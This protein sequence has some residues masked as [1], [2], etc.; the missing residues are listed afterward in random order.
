M[1]GEHTDR[2]NP[3]KKIFVQQR[4]TFVISIILFLL[5]VYST[6]HQ[7]KIE[8]CTSFIKNLINICENHEYSSEI[9]CRP[10][11][12]HPSYGT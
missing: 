6:V 5:A 9:G 1:P 11:Q 12:T 3:L 10:E 4:V 7:E 8:K 2:N